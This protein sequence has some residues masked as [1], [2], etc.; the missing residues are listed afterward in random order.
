[1]QFCSVLSFQSL[2]EL[3]FDLNLLH[4]S[5]YFLDSPCYEI[6]DWINF[7]PFRFFIN[8]TIDYWFFIVS[9]WI[10]KISTT[11]KFLFILFLSWKTHLVWEYKT[12]ESCSYKYI[13]IKDGIKQ[14]T[15]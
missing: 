2:G 3:K 6:F 10:T 5:S 9:K 1:M 12:A 13:I 14:S 8:I 15:N 7:L 11:F 4:N